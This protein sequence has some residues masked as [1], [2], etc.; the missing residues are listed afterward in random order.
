M[1][2]ALFIALLL[3]ACAGDFS[4]QLDE[5]SEG[6]GTA[7]TGDS[8]A[9]TS[10][11]DEGSSES[12]AD[13][14]TS[15]DSSG[16]GTSDPD[17]TSSSES[18][19]SSTGTCDT[20]E[21]CVPCGDFENPDA[22]CAEN[23]PERPVCNVESGS[24]VQCSPDN[25]AACDGSTPVC[26]A[27]ECVGC[28][29]HDECPDTACDI[30][31]GACFDDACV[32]EVD[33]DGGE[34]YSSLTTAIDDG[35]VVILHERNGDVPYTES[36]DIDGIKVA[37]L[38]A[39]GEDPQVQG[40]GGSP[41]IHIGVG[42]TVYIVGMRLRGN[43]GAAGLDLDDG[44]VY[45]DDSQIVQNAGGGVVGTGGELHAR[46]SFVGGNGGN[47]FSPTTGL[48]LDGVDVSL[49][50]VTVAFNEG[51]GADSFQCSA[52]TGTLRNSIVLGSD[53]ASFDCPGV[54]ADHTAFDD[55]IAG[56][57]NED[58]SPASGAWF[59][60][61][62]SDF[63]VTVSGASTFSAVAEWTTGDPA[64]DIDGTDARPSSDG[65]PDVAGADVLP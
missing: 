52:T 33:G 62:V 19:S 58:V 49:S 17:T 64:A 5:S 9:D 48:E 28:S 50:Y 40:V 23:F 21:E 30:S 32:R 43:T 16:T 37:I 29:F 6:S 18:S 8:V 61:P 27:G 47:G 35:C 24:C 20:I 57:G 38:T 54:S 63:H 45:V 53:P 56:A 12:S 39:D 25:A 55:V 36:V 15:P 13:P 2:R 26:S 11:S 7:S 51:D 10:S 59:A 34:I 44:T 46:N 4:V 14:T 41:T 42:S 3:A 65:S 31:T 1:Q 22:A 60:N